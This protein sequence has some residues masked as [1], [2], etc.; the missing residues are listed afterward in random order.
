MKKWTYAILA[1]TLTAGLAACNGSNDE[2]DNNIVFG[3]NQIGN[4]EQEFIIT[5]NQTIKKGVYL[6][7]G[8]CYVADGATLVIE[9]GTVIKGDNETRAALIVEPGGQIIARGTAELPIVFTSE[10][11]PGQRKPGDWGGLILCGNARNNQGIMQV[12]GGPRTM[13]GGSKDTDNSGILSYVRI[14]FAGSP[15]RTNQEIN[16]LTLGSVGSNTQID[17]IQVSYSND[18]AFEWFGGTVS[19]NYLVAYHTWDD[20]FDADNGYRGTATNLLGIRHPRIADAST[21]HGFECSSSS[22]AEPQTAPTFSN[23]NLYGPSSTDVEFE[24]TTTYI[25]GA[26]LLPDNQSLLGLYGAAIALS[27]NTAVNFKNANINGYPLNW[28]GTAATQENVTFGT[29]TVSFPTWT[30]G[31]C[32]FDPQNTVY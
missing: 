2:T 19:P 15:L 10:K 13:H 7:K 21:S 1:L 8:W 28:E 18:D 22:N 12:E 24:N 11:A 30:Y 20:D 16:G 6:L 32:N 25:N 17:H 14:E 3:D 4:G 26:G 23:V 31:W 27:S 29:A 5:H 9:A